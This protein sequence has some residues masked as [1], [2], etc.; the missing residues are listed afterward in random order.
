[1]TLLA[2]GCGTDPEPGDSPK[3]V[4]GVELVPASAMVPVQC[5]RAAREVGYPVPC[6]GLLPKESFSTPPVIGGC[7]LRLIGPGCFQ[8]RRWLVGSIEFPSTVR[9][10]HLVFQGSPRP[11]PPARFVHGPAWWPGAEVEI[12][13]RSRLRGLPAQWIQVPDGSGATLGGHLVLMW[14][15]RSHTYGVGFHGHDHG[16]K[17]L[18]LAV[19]GSLAMVGRTQPQAASDT[20]AR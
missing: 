17:A 1:V 16:A 3:K 4:A 19:A 14:T 10:G 15:E 20:T 8:W 12:V 7:R 9:V 5:E 18:D 6:P 13:G 11:Q 2:T